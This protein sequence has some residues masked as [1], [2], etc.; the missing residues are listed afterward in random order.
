MINEQGTT[1]GWQ[2]MQDWVTANGQPNIDFLDRS[3]GEATVNV[4][5]TTRQAPAASIG[6]RY[7]L[8]TMWRA[9]CSEDGRGSTKA[10]LP[11]DSLKGIVSM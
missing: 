1:A 5:D 11:I 2:A 3:F 9:L 6:R 10:L 4:T 8:G 7:L